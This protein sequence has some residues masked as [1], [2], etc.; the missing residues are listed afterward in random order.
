MVP[1]AKAVK[2]NEFTAKFHECMPNG[3]LH[4]HAM[5]R[6]LQEM[7]TGHADDLGCGYYDLIKTNCYWVLSNIKVAI[8]KLPRY[9]EVFFIKTWPSGLT[10]LLAEREFIVSNNKGETLL[11][12]SSQWLIMNGDNNRPVN[13]L[14][15]KLNLPDES[16]K[17]FSKRLN[18]LKAFTSPETSSR[19]T[20]PFSSLDVN[21]HVNNTA[22][23]RWAVDAV[24]RQY[25]RFPDIK[26]F[27]FTYLSEVYLADE[28]EILFGEKN[29]Q[30]GTLEILG[31]NKSTGKSAFLSMMMIQSDV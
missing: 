23:I 3:K 12:A 22:Y 16:E 4:L 24:C 6:Y 26:A 31:K 7:A 29:E 14:E 17:V 2:S 15:K 18:R 9:N 27:Q 10:K 30:N 19:L 1:T 11:L 28:L 25:G 13:L 8:S 21:G 20:V 5:S